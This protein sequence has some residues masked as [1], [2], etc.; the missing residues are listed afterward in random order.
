MK[1]L[2]SKQIDEFRDRLL[3]VVNSR[4]L[5]HLTSSRGAFQKTI[6]VA[7]VDNVQELISKSENTIAGFFDGKDLAIKEV[8][9]HFQA[10]P[11]LHHVVIRCRG[12]K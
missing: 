10:Y 6:F 4:N 11:M 8:D 7:E 2:N 12:K 3:E 9:V 5:G 1:E